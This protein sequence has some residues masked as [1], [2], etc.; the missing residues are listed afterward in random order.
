MH[1]ICK[2]STT[3]ISTLSYIEK[4]Y[5]LPTGTFL[6]TYEIIYLSK[7]KLYVCRNIILPTSIYLRFFDALAPTQFIECTIEIILTDLIP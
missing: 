6:I 1:N 5:T 4:Q 7:K 2:M 3:F